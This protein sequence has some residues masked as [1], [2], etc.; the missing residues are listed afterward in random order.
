MD[1]KNAF[2]LISSAVLAG[3][4]C[5]NGF[6]EPKTSS[7]KLTH[8][9]RTVSKMH[10][11]QHTVLDCYGWARQSA[12]LDDE[13]A[14]SLCLGADNMAPVAC[15]ERA[16]KETFLSQPL[17]VSLCRCARTTKPVECIQQGQRTTT[18]EDYQLVELCS[19]QEQYSVIGH[20]ASTGFMPKLR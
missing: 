7:Q 5:L 11:A 16:M 17:S 14:I 12:L 20:C 18:L 3:M 2:R 9:V 10:V 19:P 8:P 13:E 4:I 1:N 15:Y 6:A